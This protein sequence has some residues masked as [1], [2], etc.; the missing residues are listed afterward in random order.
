MRRTRRTMLTFCSCVLAVGVIG[1]G[2]AGASSEWVTYHANN[3]RTGVDS[4]EPSLDPAR[5]AWSNPLDGAAVFGQPVVA[6]GRVFVATEDDDVYALDA[7]DG[8]V[9]WA[10][11][12]GQPLQNVDE[13]TGCGDIDPLG[14][15]S[16]PVI[17]LSRS[18]VYVVGE[19]TDRGALPVTHL[20]VGF[21]MLSGAVTVRSNADPVLPAGETTYQIQQRTALA[22]AN[23]R[24]YVGYGGLA[25]DCG[26]YH[27]WVVGVNESGV[28]PKVQFD[29]TP[30]S[31][32][33]AIWMGGGGPSVD[34]A[35][36]VYVETG[37][38]NSPP[39]PDPWA[40]AVVKLAPDLSSPPEAVFQDPQA[41]GDADLTTNPVLLPG[42]EVFGVGKTD[43]G[44]LLQQSDLHQVAPISGTVCGSDPDGG[45][46]YD[47][48]TNSVY[49]PCSGGGIQQ[50]NLSTRR[51]GWRA[52]AVNSSPILVDGELWALDYNDAG[53]LQELN[54][55]TGAVIQSISVGDSVPHFASPSSAD[56][57]LLVGTN[58]GIRAFDGPS[59]PPPP[60]PTLG[61][62]LTAADGG[63][64]SF[65]QASFHGS[66]GGMRLDQPVVGIAAAPNGQGYWL[67]ARDGGIFS[68]GSAAFHG[69]LGNL[70]LRAPIV[71]IAPT[72]SGKGYWLVAADGGVFS[73]GDARFH[74]S[75]GNT[76]LD[77]P[78]VGIAATTTGNGYWLVAADGGVFTFGDARFHGSTGDLHLDQPIIGMAA[79]PNGRGYWLAA[80]DG[81]I[82]TFGTADFHGSLGNL[83]LDAPIV[84]IAPTSTGGGYW[85]VASDGGVFT[86][87]DGVFLGSLGGHHLDAPIVAAATAP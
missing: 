20:L 37:N 43:V 4:S 62:W 49:V 14:I 17:D 1:G 48:A 65:G 58:N 50:V 86:F 23:G 53:T 36:N 40:Y 84:A 63:V 26:T 22:V 78:I 7:H 3:S 12:I 57:L 83:H 9:L 54:P 64:F 35:G 8:R 30:Q 10:A 61:Y 15:T 31:S 46:A 85:L 39:T 68:Y 67:A 21:N 52:G 32:G 69:S 87:G 44:F 18:T 47:Q 70:H 28:G 25:G 79:T 13:V 42:G 82:F 74:G 73:F 5:L 29:A 66:T 2:V 16:T 81:G 27:G 77:A 24:V 56:G 71:G 76:R 34:A 55:T 33:G 60:A 59:G 72:P 38:P 80:R 11:N 45:P 6:D 41:S 19:V 75:L 51:T